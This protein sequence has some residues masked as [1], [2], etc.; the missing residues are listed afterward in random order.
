[1]GLCQSKEEVVEPPRKEEPKPIPT[2][3]AVFDDA[4][5]F[6]DTLN[7]LKT[8]QKVTGGT[9][10]GGGQKPLRLLNIVAKPIEFIANFVAPV[11]EKTEKEKDFIRSAIEGNFVFSHLA[12]NEISALVNAFEPYRVEK[13]SVIIKQG[14][15][16][17][18][19]YVIDKGTVGFIKDGKSVGQATP[20]ATFGE[21]ALL[22]NCPRAA[23]CTALK[24]A[25]ELYRV[26]QEIFR[27]ILMS[28][29][30]SIDKEK[31]EVLKSLDIF[32]N[33]DA[34]ELLQIAEAS[35]EERYKAGQSIIKK[36]DTGDKFY[37]VKDGLIL[38]TD[39]IIGESSYN[40]T[41]FGPGGFFG[42]AAIMSG[43][44]YRA[45]VRAKV[46]TTLLT[47]EKDIF[48]NLVG[49]LEESI[50]RSRARD[51]LRLVP[52]IAKSN[53]SDSDM[54]KLI[55]LFNQMTYTKGHTFCTLEK[56]IEPTL[57]VIQS[58]SVSR[59]NYKGKTTVIG[60]HE[61]FGDETFEVGKKLVQSRYTIEALEDVTCQALSFTAVQIA[62]A[63]L[64]SSITGPPEK[65]GANLKK[66]VH[67]DNLHKHR[68]L[69]A[70]TF[71][72]VWLT[73][74]KRTN[75]PFALK[76][77]SKRLLIDYNQ[78]DGV[79]REK[80]IMSRLNSPFIIQMV[81]AFQD[82]K[83]LY[84]VTKLY[85]G[86]E[87][88]NI[89]HRKQKLTEEECVFYAAGIFEGLTYMHQRKVIYRDLKPENVLLD[90]DG[91]CV[92]VDLGFA[93]VVRHKTYTLCGTPLY[94]APE[95]ILQRGHDK[96][97]DIW[98]FGVL[99]YE[100]MLG[101]TPFYK[102][103]MDQRDLFQTICSSKY[104]FPPHHGKSPEVIDLIMKILILRPAKRLGCLSGGNDDIRKH[105]WFSRS[106]DF[107]KLRKKH[108]RAPWIPDIHDPLD[109]SNFEEYEEDVYN[110]RKDK[111]LSKHEQSEFEDF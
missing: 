30:A 73:S 4:F 80:D 89:M 68:I 86:G 12:E 20:G 49:S 11:H 100:M 22:Y 37:V 111:P 24:D 82:D 9:E 51:V 104:T 103:G 58:G 64:S 8:F 54:D 61:Y 23:T 110:Y 105:G 48:L 79:L 10:Q 15:I 16:G 90:S 85:Q 33:V 14:D 6:L 93:K 95:V 57:Y 94:I 75:A 87:L 34:K 97:A 29:A 99:L 65:E 107:E 42:E 67:L 28:N 35:V 3:Q 50:Q 70:G 40:D 21:L 109:S 56:S 92:I 41:S 66:T 69:G 101:D 7:P 46:E 52:L 2:P 25:C 91:Y 18:Y 71:G 106:I 39:I 72:Q 102:D 47:I 19:F 83:C 36:G 74:D 77:Q 5:A 32:K 108:I 43:N 31:L 1:M 76:I 26:D 17:D 27:R 81:N 88:F 55:S 84:M 96:G 63:K 44:P 62:F 45:N 60:K 98:S 13:G 53:L 38:C 78:S 59:T